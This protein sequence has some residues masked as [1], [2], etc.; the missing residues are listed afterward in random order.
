[1]SRKSIVIIMI[2]ISLCPAWAAGAGAI[3]VFIT[4]SQ[5]WEMSGASGGSKSGFGGGFSG[6]ARPQT[7]E[8]IKTFN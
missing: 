2:V 5:S 4:G 8:I 1:M 3:R 7:A 6:G